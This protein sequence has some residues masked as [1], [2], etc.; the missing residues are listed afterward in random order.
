MGVEGGKGGG[1][2]GCDWWQGGPIFK[3]KSAFHTMKLLPQSSF[4]ELHT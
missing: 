2:T 4:V 1:P 3:I